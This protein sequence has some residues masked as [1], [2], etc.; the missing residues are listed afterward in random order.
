MG[1]E[2]P[3]HRGAPGAEAGAPAGAQQESVFDT[4]RLVRRVGL[5]VVV[6]VVVVAA[7]ATLPGVGEVRARLRS[8]E[9]G[10]IALAAIS[11][12]GSV[13]AFVA[14]LL[15]A[16][17][18]VVPLRRGLTLGLA[19]QGANVLLPAGGTG[20]PAFGTF[21]MRRAGVP[22]EIAAERHVALFLITSAVGFVSLLLFGVL[23]AAGALPGEAGL[24]GTLGPAVVGGGVLAGAVAF[25]R[26]RHRPEP[27][28]GR[29]V[30]HLVWRLQGFLRDGVRT[31]L[32]LLR[33]HDAL[34]LGGAVAYY[35]LD[36]AALGAAFQAF[37][38]GGPPVGLFVLAYTIGHAGAFV[39]TPGGVG[40]TDGGLIGAFVAYGAPLDLATAAVLSY[41]V[42]QLGLPAILGALGLVSIRRRLRLHPEPLTIAAR[43]AR[44]EQAGVATGE[45]SSR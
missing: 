31:S 9:S 19:E 28:A 1:L 14:A 36:V 3:E 4:G 7:F 17:D 13:F 35:A 38:G 45:R 39:P 34:L 12:L 33:E 22:A 20:G 26:G 44:L 21:V 16:F 37:G 30:G 11:S 24:A 6:A 18:R 15:G 32:A 5:F 42:F 43:F 25:A 23:E 29:R 2:A 8:A 10:W 27:D 41:R 40:G